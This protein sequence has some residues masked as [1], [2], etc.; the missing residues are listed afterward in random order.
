MH[1]FLTATPYTTTFNLEQQTKAGRLKGLI[2][3]NKVIYSSIELFNFYPISTLCFL[4]KSS[5]FFSNPN[6]ILLAIPYQVFLLA[7]LFFIEIAWPA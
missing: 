4:L 7:W 3:S 1:L 2:I 6:R 5:T